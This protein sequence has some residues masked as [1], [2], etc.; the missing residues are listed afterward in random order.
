MRQALLDLLLTDGHSKI[1]PEIRRELLAGRGKAVALEL[2]AP[3]FGGDN[4]T[5]VD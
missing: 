3:T 1:G 4:T 2:E 5:I